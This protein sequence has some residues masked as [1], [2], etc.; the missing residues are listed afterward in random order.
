MAKQKRRYIYSSKPRLTILCSFISIELLDAPLGQ[1]PCLTVD[2][3]K[4]PQSVSIARFV[5]KKFNL[6]GSDDL[7]QAKTDAVV[8]TASDLQNAYYRYVFSFKEEERDTA[9]KAFEAGEAVAHLE[10]I[11]KLISLWGSN[12]HS[13]GSSL[14]WSDLYV[15]DTSKLIAQDANVLD[16][17]PGI[18]AVNKSVESIPAVAEYLKNRAVTSF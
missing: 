17:Y 7:E 18:L 12:G 9:K 13:V 10:K 6:Y 8:D 1:L 2:G 3:F 5:A 16:K 15:L 14:K 4:L 11:E